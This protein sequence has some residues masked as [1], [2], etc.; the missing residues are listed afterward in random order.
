MSKVNILHVID[1]LGV[2]G[3]ERLMIGVVKE[4]TEYQHHII[5]LTGPDTLKNELDDNVKVHCL[6]FST[7]WDIPSCIWTI[8][9]YI[10]VNDI[11][12][13]HSHL[14]LA[15]MIARMACPRHVKLF[16]SLHSTIGSRFFSSDKSIKRRI[17][18]LLY[19]KRHHII[20][21]SKEVLRDYDKIIGIKGKSSVLCNFVE[22]RVFAKEYKHKDFNTHLKVVAVGNLKPAK[23]YSFLIDAFRQ[24]PMNISLDIFG[25]GSLRNELQSAIDKYH[26][27][28]RLCG[29]QNNI[30][31]LL[32]KYDLYVMSSEVE[33]YG[34]ALLEAMAAGLPALVSD[35]P[36]LRET[37]GN[38][39]LYFD[40]TN[41]GDFIQK[42]TDIANHQIDID[43][44]AKANFE[45]AQKIGKKESY[46]QN[47]RNLY[48]A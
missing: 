15:T 11:S 33:G 27:N 30:H 24:L 45:Y 14:V 9:K 13:V 22:T 23:N 8:R 40:L 25:E 2:G 16:N 37:T 29:S 3:A 6:N 26:V 41:S 5:Y 20:A 28:I 47:L 7:K 1:S 4:L 35:I 19:K 34:I 46:L 44:Y 48:N 21:V 32:R 17:E 42:I 18:K 43:Q 38:N 10:K 12:I 31:E 36:V 39:G